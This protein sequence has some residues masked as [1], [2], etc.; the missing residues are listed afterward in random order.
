VK[1]KAELAIRVL[2]IVCLAALW[3][4]ALAAPNDDPMFKNGVL[5]IGTV[6]MAA[7]QQPWVAWL[8]RVGLAVVVWPLCIMVTALLAATMSLDLL[9][10]IFGRGASVAT[11]GV[12]LLAIS[13]G[14][15]LL[16]GAWV[17]PWLWRRWT[18]TAPSGGERR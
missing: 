1:R 7:A 13:L 9:D 3:M 5:A 4:S 8:R 15:A 6:G 12:E 10:L 14:E 11:F 2:G 18:P 17:L 16:L